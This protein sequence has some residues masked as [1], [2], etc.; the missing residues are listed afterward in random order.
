MSD[1]EL[2]IEEVVEPLEAALAAVTEDDNG[3]SAETI[4]AAQDV[5]ATFGDAAADHAEDEPR[6]NEAAEGVEELQS[7]LDSIAVGEADVAELEYATT[8]IQNVLQGVIA[9]VLETAIADAT[10]A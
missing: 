4:A 9:A 8:Q 7:A 1:D 2:T 10:D 5:I 6:F 3:A